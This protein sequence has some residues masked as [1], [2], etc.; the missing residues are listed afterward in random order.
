M[1]MA[2][3]AVPAIVNGVICC[4][5]SLFCTSAVLCSDTCLSFILPTQELMKPNPMRINEKIPCVGTEGPQHARPR[6]Q[7]Y[8][9]MRWAI[10]A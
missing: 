2:S 5:V 9:L 7:V 4:W 3:H 8:I 6:I 1:V 10:I